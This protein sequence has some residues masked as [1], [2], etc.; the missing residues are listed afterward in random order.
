MGQTNKKEY[1]IRIPKQLIHYRVKNVDYWY[2]LPYEVVGLT[3]LSEKQEKSYYGKKRATYE[4]AKCLIRQEIFWK[5]YDDSKHYN[6]PFEPFR[7]KE[8]DLG[9]KP[10]FEVKRYRKGE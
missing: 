4:A 6:T 2:R 1:E 9:D 5:N 7:F 10:W 3:K 8:F